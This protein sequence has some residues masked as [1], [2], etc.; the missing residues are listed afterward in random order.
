MDTDPKAGASVSKNSAVDLV[1]SAGPAVNVPS[2]V[3]QQLTPAT[4][5]ISDAGLSY[6]VK[7]V[8]SDKPIGT[9]LAQSPVRQCEGQVVHEGALDR[10]GHP[11]VGLGA[12]RARADSGVG[13]LDPQGCR[14]QRRQPDQ[15]VLWPVWQR[16]GVLPEPR[17]E[18]RRHNRMPPSTS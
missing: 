9:V 15:W 5:L 3:G 10:V 17:T 7:Y 1:V 2:V 14:A 6:L 12:E 18:R 4:Q 16:G 11:D 8:T 13:R